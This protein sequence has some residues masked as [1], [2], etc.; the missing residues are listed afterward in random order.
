MINTREVRTLGPVW[1]LE[2]LAAASLKSSSVRWIFLVSF[3]RAL[4][5]DLL[6]GGG[7]VVVVVVFGGVVGMV[8]DRTLSRLVRARSSVVSV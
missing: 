3:S 2:T 1:N 5:A 7:G 8:E 6:G 4:V